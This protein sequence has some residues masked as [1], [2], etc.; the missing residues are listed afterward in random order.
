FKKQIFGYRTGEKQTGSIIKKDEA[1]YGSQD[2]LDILPDDEDNIL[3]ALYPWRDMG[4]YWGINRNAIPKVYRLNINTG[5]KKKVDSLPM[6]LASGLTD[7]DGNLRFSSAID[8][9][10]NSVIHYKEANTKEWKKFDLK[11]F[12]GVNVRPIGFASDS[13]HAY[14]TANAGLGT[15]AL[16]EID[17]KN[18]GYKKIHH[19]PKVDISRFVTDLDTKKV[20]A[21]G[22]VLGKPEYLYLNKSD[23]AAKLHKGLRKSFGDSEIRITSVTKDHKYAVILAFSDVNSGDYF[24][25][26]TETFAADYLFSRHQ[27]LFPEVMAKTK[28]VTIKTRDNFEIS[29][30]LTKPKGEQKG[31]VVFPHGGPHGIRDYWGFDWEVQLL[32]NRG[33]AVLQV[34]YRGSGG[35][36]EAFEVMGHGQWGGLMIND[37]TDATKQ[38]LKEG[39]AKS[40]KVCIYGASYGGYAALMSA[41]KEPNLYKC[42]IGAMGVY[43]LPL[44]YETGDIADRK[45]G[46]AYLKNVLGEE[47]AK[48]QQF[49]P[50]NNASKIKADVLLIHGK[51]DERVPI[52]HAQMM[53]SSLDKANKKYEWLE[54]SD[55][56]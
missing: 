20:V 37:I 40:G 14:V 32:A 15:R 48:L 50:A 38:M 51:Q 25:M 11:G 35:F 24:L 10:N 18:G 19:D 53:M 16:Y 34:N 17:L 1:E 9:E 36:G 26:N 55:E 5:R 54:V 2:I 23:P 49:S 44:M 47:Q 12:P 29:G 45:S 28:P 46:I 33:Y 22:T 39:H 7:Y 43:S 8:D 13:D 3:V 52:E 31:L 56:G 4:T 42:T 21:V 27:K 41:V 30:Y 6:P